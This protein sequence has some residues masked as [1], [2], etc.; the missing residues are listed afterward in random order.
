LFYRIL[1]VATSALM[2][3]VACE[4]I[5]LPTLPPP[6]QGDPPDTT[7]AGTPPARTRLGRVSIQIQSSITSPTPSLQC[8]LDQEPFAPCTSPY[9]REGLR[10]G[11]H[12]FRAF[13]TLPDGRADPTPAVATWEIVAAE[14]NT[15]ITSAPES[16]TSATTALI[17]FSSNEA[18]AAFEC[19][20]DAAAFAA[21]T[22]PQSLTNLGAGEHRFRVRA[23]DAEMVRDETP[24][25]HVWTVDASP[26][27]VTLVQ[28]PTDVIETSSFTF[29]FQVSEEAARVFCKLDAAA[30]APCSSPHTVTG[31]TAGAHQFAVY[32]VDLAGNR[33][34]PDTAGFSVQWALGVSCAA[35]ADCKSGFCRDG[36][37]C[38]AA[39]SGLCQN[40][41]VGR[42][43]CRAVRN[44]ADPDSCPGDN[45]CDDNSQCTAGGTGLFDGFEASS[46]LYR[47]RGRFPTGAIEAEGA[48]VRF[49]GEIQ[50]VP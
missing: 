7:L 45:H 47:F 4:R 39:C 5:T 41:A 1:G 15:T 35:A 21:C 8:S 40:C 49:K 17:A 9:T 43:M 28:K 48:S 3:G 27:A 19:S 34:T 10:P 13:A 11:I 44:G 46:P 25:E 42:G 50:S 12:T 37:C 32:A 20:L 24:A 2:V 6:A 18:G 14:L 31:L 29:T 22:T 23:V 36:V 30:A 33:S 26:P 38:D 16:V